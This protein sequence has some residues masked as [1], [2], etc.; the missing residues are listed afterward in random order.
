MQLNTQ[1]TFEVWAVFEDGIRNVTNYAQVDVADTAVVSKTGNVL[2]SLSVG[3]SNIT[4]TLGSFSVTKSISVNSALLTDIFFQYSH[5]ELF[6]G[7][8]KTLK[9]YGNYDNGETIEVTGQ[10]SISILDDVSAPT[11][12]LVYYSSTKKLNAVN[13]STGTITATF[14]GQTISKTFEV[15]SAAITKIE[16]SP[17]VL[18]ARKESSKAFLATAFF[19]DGSVID[20][21]QDTNWST[22]NAA[23]SEVNYMGQKGVIYF[24][25]EGTLNVIANYLGKSASTYVDVSLPDPNDIII[26]TTSNNVPQGQTAQIT[27]TADYGSGNFKDVTEDA[28]FIS[29][30]TYAFT[31]SNAPGTKGNVTSV[32]TGSADITITY[33]GFSKQETFITTTAI[34]QSI[35]ISPEAPMVPKGIDFAMR[36]WGHYNDGS[37]LEITSE[38]DFTS[39]NSSLLEMSSI[40]GEEGVARNVS[41][42]TTIQS[43]TITASCLSMSDS[44]NAIV[45]PSNLIDIAFS[46]SDSTL[47]KFDILE[48]KTYGIFD[49]GA[50]QDISEYVNW[51]S[52]DQG[53]VNVSSALDEQGTLTAVAPGSA[54]ITAGI[55]DFTISATFTVDDTAEKSIN[56]VGLG[57][58]GEYYSCTFA[59]N[60]PDLSSLVFQGG[61]ID[62]NVN[63]SWSTGSAPLGVGDN[64]YVKWTGYFKPEESGNYTFFTNSNDGARLYVGKDKV[65]EN[66]SIHTTTLDQGTVALEAGYLY[67]IQLE[68]FEKGGQAVIELYYQTSS[69]AQT[70]IPQS[71]LFPA[72]SSFRLKDPIPPPLVAIGTD[73]P[74]VN[75]KVSNAVDL[76]IYAIYSDGTNAQIDPV[77]VTLSSADTGVASFDPSVDN[78]LHLNASGQTLVTA[79]YQSFSTNVQVL[80]QASTPIALDV[81]LDSAALHPGNKSKYNAIATF[82]DG[83]T[84]DVSSDVGISS[85]DIST[86]TTSGGKWQAIS[87]GSADLTFSYEGL[88]VVKSV[89]V[90]ALSIN[91]IKLVPDLPLLTNNLSQKLDIIGVLSDSSEIPLYG[92]SVTSM[93]SQNY[94]ADIIGSTL[95]ITTKTVTSLTND[96]IELS[97]VGATDTIPLTVI[98]GSLASIEFNVENFYLNTYDS[99]QLEVVGRLSDGGSINLTEYAAFESSSPNVAVINSIKNKGTA[100]ALSAGTTSLT[101]TFGGLSATVSLDVGASATSFDTKGTGLNA[102]YYSVTFVDNLPDLANKVLKGNRIDSNIDFDWGA[103][104]CPVDLKNSFYVVWE[105]FISIPATDNYT[106]ST[107]S[108]DGV[109]V[110]IDDL[111]NPKISNWTDH[112]ETTDTSSVLALTEGLYPIR[113]EFFNQGGGAT[114]QMSWTSDGGLSGIISPRYFYSE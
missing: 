99:K 102:S 87:A 101:A 15:K 88:S 93:T 85:S 22:D 103:V 89:T 31:V 114:M 100:V 77:D 80:S 55:N 19:D 13:V 107:V 27:V 92:C 4:A 38:C 41:L 37:T 110:F 81:T 106:F 71:L 54:T 23:I 95:S 62:G 50:S 6:V 47:H 111:V 24:S 58:T 105:G 90:N 32:G 109:K 33:A 3:T 97:C 64:F 36:A 18:N 84:Y 20:V 56:T 82:A 69:V 70:P 46:H 108:D 21:T 14:D 76:N 65:I 66:W 113:I 43:V 16:I 52:S 112:P 34:L 98:T 44:T 75:E 45:N 91:T 59:G 79:T 96:S 48:L 42:N 104:N 57:L 10:V 68:F 53:I 83:S 17:A 2:S 78:R 74:L 7:Q 11:T 51:S 1:T 5:Y 28:V 94:D 61:R 39:S 86:A 30:N 72:D 49:D 9:V 26:S 73:R 40:P 25:E 35:S 67:P 60:T 12:D 63:F 29:S 8:E